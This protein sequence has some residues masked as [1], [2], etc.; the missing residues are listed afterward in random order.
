M[1]QKSVCKSQDA[2]SL[3]KTELAREWLHIHRWKASTKH[4]F[5]SCHHLCELKNPVLFHLR[6]HWERTRWFWFFWLWLFD[7][8]ERTQL[9]PVAP[10]RYCV[11]HTPEN[12]IPVWFCAAWPPT[13][14]SDCTH[15]MPMALRIA[16]FILLGNYLSHQMRNTFFPWL[17]RSLFS[18]FACWSG[19]L[20]CEPVSLVSEAVFYTRISVGFKSSFTGLDW[21]V[22][23]NYPVVLRLPKIS[24]QLLVRC[25]DHC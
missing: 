3:V 24:C 5:A 22:Y 10:C 2:I 21:H 9:L 25:L 15:C 6:I 18:I 19:N 14:L 7:L 20:L 16:T 11:P 8:W 13:L 12:K 1:N 23:N 4:F 17:P